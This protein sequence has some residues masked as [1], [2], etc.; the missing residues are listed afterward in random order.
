MYTVGIDVGG[1]KIA[2]GLFDGQGM[3]VEKYR[4]PSNANL[5][6]AEF[7]D[8]ILVDI[9]ELLERRGVSLAE[10]RGVGIGLPSF[11][12]YEK[13]YIL[14]TSALTN[15][16]DFYAR[17]YL[18]RGLG[19]NVEVRLDND[20]HVAALAEHRKGAGRGFPNMLYCPV[21][22]GISSALIIDGRIF[23]G[24]YGFAGES[25]HQIITPGRGI[26]CGCGNRGC[27][28]SYA[29][30]GMLVRHVCE[31]IAQGR[32]TI[33]SSLVSDPSQIT[34]EHIA[35]AYDQG[36]TLAWKAIAQMAEFM[37]VWLF[38]LYV[39]LNINCYVFGGGLLH[40]GERLFPTIRRQFDAYKNDDYPVYFKTAALGEDFGIIGAAQLFE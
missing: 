11:V 32:A 28:M 3:I 8:E 26:S 4:R 18:E 15:L 12:E 9:G 34:V 6:A 19:G 31:W 5:S 38:N 39:T 23:R 22:T 2:Y 1:T 20:A 24:S 33:I 7:F 27:L 29:S 21:S 37:A 16:H 40:L 14:K 25:G 35:Q 10:L 13:G 30:G 17:D 36:D